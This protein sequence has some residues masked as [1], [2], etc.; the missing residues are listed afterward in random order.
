M[1]GRNPFR[2]RKDEQPKASKPI[3]RVDREESIA[4]AAE[5]PGGEATPQPGGGKLVYVDEEGRRRRLPADLSRL[6][7]GERDAAIAAMSSAL[8]ADPDYARVAALER[9]AELRA[10][11]AIPEETFLREKRR[12]ESGG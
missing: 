2:R 5:E 4:R 7:T 8:G 10:S 9:L 12:L 11:G 3:W 6:S 1:G